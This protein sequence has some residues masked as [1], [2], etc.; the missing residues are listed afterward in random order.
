[1]PSFTK[2]FK[3]VFQTELDMGREG[4]GAKAVTGR[5]RVGGGPPDAL[6]GGGPP[7]PGTLKG[8][9]CSSFSFTSKQYY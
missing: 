9:I 7:F 5:G 1:M 6:R 3:N 4:M 2:Y 8:K